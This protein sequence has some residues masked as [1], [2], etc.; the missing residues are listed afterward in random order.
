MLSAPAPPVTVEV[1]TLPHDC[2]GVVT[3]FTL[4]AGSSNTTRE[5]DGVIAVTTKTVELSGHRFRRC[6]Q[7]LHHQ[8]ES[9][10]R[11]DQWIQG[12]RCL[13]HQGQLLRR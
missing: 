13:H 9:G 5:V 6:C 1:K 4:D 7:H 2:D 10:S 3:S 11:T 12:C 8:S